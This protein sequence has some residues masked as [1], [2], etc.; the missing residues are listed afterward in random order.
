MPLRVISIQ[1]VD[2][3]VLLS[4]GRGDS[5]RQTLAH[6]RSASVGMLPC[7]FK[8]TATELPSRVT[9]LGLL[10]YVSFGGVWC[11]PGWHSDSIYVF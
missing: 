6:A 1:L 3:S 5:N 8:G 7:M 9:G 11:N 10:F 2:P 4:R